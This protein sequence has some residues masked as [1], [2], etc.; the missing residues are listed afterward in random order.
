MQQY[1]V[2][3][4]DFV[5]TSEAYSN[6]LF[7]GNGNVLIPYISQGLMPDNPI[8]GKQ[9]V[10]DF[11]Y[12]MLEGVSTMSFGALWT[13][14]TITVSDNPGSLL[15]EY[16][17]FGIDD[18]AEVKILCSGLRLFIPDSSII[19]SCHQPFV[20]YDIGSPYPQYRQNIDRAR[21]VSFFEGHDLPEEIKGI[22]GS[23]IQKL[24]WTGEGVHTSYL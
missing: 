5:N 22:L 21:A 1:V 9:T 16:I 7:I 2:T 4:L 15:E 12:Y 11:S 19:R 10:I 8:N 6:T 13:T 17:M 23:P 20:P 14:F 18:G 24:T 3:N